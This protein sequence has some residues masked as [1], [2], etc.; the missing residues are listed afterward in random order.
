MLTLP[1]SSSATEPAPLAAV[2]IGLLFVVLGSVLLLNILNIAGR[3][4]G[5]RSARS[6]LP[7]GQTSSPLIMYRI[8]GSG[9]VVAGLFAAISGIVRAF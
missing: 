7:E 4:H 2:L 5:N 1:M 8:V 3:M 6:R 9:F